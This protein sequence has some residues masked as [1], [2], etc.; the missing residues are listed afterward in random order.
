MIFFAKIYPENDDV[1]DTLSALFVCRLLYGL[2]QGNE[3]KYGKLSKACNFTEF[4][5]NRNVSCF[6]NRIIFH[7]NGR[8]KEEKGGLLILKI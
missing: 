7:S 5:F 2:R 3:R 4:K 6:D 8:I 1:I